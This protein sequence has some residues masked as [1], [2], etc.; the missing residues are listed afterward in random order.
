MQCK[1][2]GKEIKIGFKK[3]TSFCS[4]ECRRKFYSPRKIFNCIVCGK[5]LVG[6]QRQFCSAEC[7]L[8]DKAKSQQAKN[9]EIY[10]AVKMKPRVR[11]KPKMSI[12]EINAKA[13]AE[14]LNY[15]Q[16]VAK[17]GL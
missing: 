8:K 15:G 4:D 16:Y 5:K 10:K 9:K 13:R 17:Y 6:R 12:E 7:R 1:Y 14:G 11:H 2:C 3:R